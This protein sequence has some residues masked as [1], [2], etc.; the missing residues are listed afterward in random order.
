MNEIR[1][2]EKPTKSSRMTILSKLNVRPMG[3]DSIDSESSDE[4]KLS[5]F[6]YNS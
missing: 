5:I 6:N 3:G 2:K 4:S 1:F